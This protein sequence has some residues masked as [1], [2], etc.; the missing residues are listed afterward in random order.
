M[1][2]AFGKYT[3]TGGSLDFLRPGFG[4]IAIGLGRPF[5]SSDADRPLL[6]V[7]ELW[8]GVS[9]HTPNSSSQSMGN[10]V[11]SQSGWW[12]TDSGSVSF[13]YS[14]NRIFDSVSIA[15][16]RFDRGAGNTFVVRHDSEGHLSV[17][18][19]SDISGAANASEALQ[20]IKRQ[21]PH[22][23]YVASLVLDR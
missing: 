9:V 3:G 5:G 23:D 2:D 4:V 12:S 22:D 8:P 13:S 15:G 11:S 7:V 21:M 16:H 14:W 18:Q 6:Y 17:R 19:L 20:Q 1:R 10:F